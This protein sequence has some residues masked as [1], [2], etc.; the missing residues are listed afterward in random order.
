MI[1]S[2]LFTLLSTNQAIT[3]Q[4]GTRPAGDT[5]VYPVT[6]PEDP[7]LPALSYQIISSRDTPTLDD[8][9]GTTKTRVQIECW[10]ETYGAA[11]ELR[12]IVTTAILGYRGTVTTPD[13]DVKIQNIL[14]VTK[15]DVFADVPRQFT[16]K[17][18]LYIWHN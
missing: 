2:A 3:S 4:L 18:D 8:P 10:G 17:V 11:V 14:R 5:G 1:E 6:I 15:G 16:A 12:Q 13:G 7:I 9:L